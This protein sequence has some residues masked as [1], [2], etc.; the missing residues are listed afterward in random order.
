MG[1][2]ILMQ[3]AFQTTVL[4]IYLSMYYHKNIHK[5]NTKIILLRDLYNESFNYSS[6]NELNYFR[7]YNTS[8]LKYNRFSSSKC[9]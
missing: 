9:I 7:K 3:T 2:Q 4:I 5:Y 1:N 6:Q 8:S